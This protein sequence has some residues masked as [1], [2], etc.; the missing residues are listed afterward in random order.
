MK[1]MNL[2]FCFRVARLLALR[3]I[4]GAER[5]REDYD[6]LSEGYDAHFSR[7]VARH[8]LS[9]LEG[10][11]LA[12]GD[13]VLD[14]AC[15][16]GTL[17]LAAAAA[18]GERGEV[19]AVDRSHGML[20]VADEKRRRLGFNNIRFVHADMAVAVRDL[21]DESFD[22][23]TCAWAIGYANP[24]R[25]LRDIARKLRPG[26]KTGLIENRRDTLA[27][28]R[29]TAL[30]VAQARPGD[31]QCL[32]DLHR[33]LP[34][35]TTQLRRWFGGAGLTPR[36]A[37]EGHEPF[38]FARGADVLDWVLHTGASAGFDRMMS[39][40]SKEQCD[41]LFAEFIERDFMQNGTIAVAHRYVAG[42]AVREPAG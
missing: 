10:V 18:V 14:L 23:V 40:R 30:R 35:D 15:G 22:V 42:V 7:Y 6:R 39:A 27:P 17:A 24:P 31:L 41:R 38:V 34:R 13:R 26:G 19:V 29:R 25:L 21:A 8:S 20:R 1:S 2:V 28:I 16:T 33:R 9:M 36:D 37:W 5:I 32:M 11:G 4:V 12:A 3:R